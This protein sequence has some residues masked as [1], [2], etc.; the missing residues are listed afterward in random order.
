MKPISSKPTLAVHKFTSCDG[1]QLALLNMGEALLSLTQKVE[2]VHFPEAGPIAPERYVDISLVEGSVSTSDEVQ[3]IR[4]IRKRSKILVTIGSCATS[5]G[6]Q[7]L[8]NGQHLPE[9]INTVYANADTIRSLETSTPA[10]DHVSVDFQ[11]WG[12]PINQRQITQLLSSLL[13][14]VAPQDHTEKLCLECKRQQIVCV[15]VT[16]GQ[17]CMGP[18]TR[19]AC[20]ALCPQLGRGCYSC[21]GPGENS[22]T[23]ALADRFKDLGLSNSEVIRRFKFI[24]SNAGEF[25]VAVK[26]LEQSDG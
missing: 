5:G 19:T 18:V 16:Q 24:T 4:E 1:C 15:M 6:I 12:C 17:A 3:R 10:S 22:N 7:A 23:Q 2:I 13:L 14:G 9:W 11:L 21:Y 26:D 8:R 25:V 20:G